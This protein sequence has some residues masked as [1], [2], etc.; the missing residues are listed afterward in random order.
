MTSPLTPKPNSGD[1]TRSWTMKFGRKWSNKVEYLFIWYF[2]SENFEFLVI[3]GVKVC[4]NTL[5][6][7]NLSGNES[8]LG[9]L[10]YLRDFFIKQSKFFS[11]RWIISF[12]HSKILDHSWTV[13]LGP[14]FIFMT[15]ILFQFQTR[16]GHRAGFP[17]PG[18]LN[19]GLF[20]PARFSSGL[21]RRF[22]T[23]N[24]EFFK[25]EPGYSGS[26]LDFRRIGL[27]QPGNSFF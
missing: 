15:S 21:T 9:S 7:S 22:W 24:P 4:R 16:D 12:E 11:C 1:L 17:G 14:L 13:Q 20:D 2:K 10:F 5:F 18:N 6:H 23:R 25:I 3:M 27:T 26:G 8:E 19:P